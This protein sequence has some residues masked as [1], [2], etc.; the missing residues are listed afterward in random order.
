MGK[1]ITVSAWRKAKAVERIV[2]AAET[3]GEIRILNNFP[4]ALIAISDDIKVGRFGD[5][6]QKLTSCPSGDHFTVAVRRG[7]TYTITSII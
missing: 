4:T 3:D 1:G 2:L 6:I 7:V 5:F